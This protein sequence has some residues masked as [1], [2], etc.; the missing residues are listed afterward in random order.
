MK[1]LTHDEDAVKSIIPHLVAK[2]I[3]SLNISKGETGRN[4]ALSFITQ[5]PGKE[6]FQTSG[7]SSLRTFHK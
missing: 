6:K 4:A 2:D 3:A 7:L 1:R 5:L